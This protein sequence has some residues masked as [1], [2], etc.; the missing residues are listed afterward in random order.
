MSQMSTITSKKQI[1]L[2]VDAFRKAG[3]REGQKIIVTE[4]NGRLILTPAEKLVEEL[5]GSLPMPKE[6]EGRD[7]NEI[8]EEGISEYFNEKYKQ[9]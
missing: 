7:I 4:E 3:F 6:W 1:T 8:V 9:K 5:A 2:P